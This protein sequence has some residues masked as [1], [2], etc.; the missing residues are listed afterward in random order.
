MIDDDA[1]DLIV[2][3]P[4]FATDQKDRAGLA[5]QKGKL[6][7]RMLQ[8][9]TDFPEPERASAGRRYADR[10]ARFWPAAEREKLVASVMSVLSHTELGP[11]FSERSQ[12]EV[13]IMGTL[14][15]EGRDYAISGR[16]DRLVVTEDRVIILDYKTNRVPPKNLDA[17]PLSH[18]AQ[19][20]IYREILRP[21]YPAKNFDCVL[22]YTESA[23][24]V[25]LP[26]ELLSRSLAELKTK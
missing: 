24:V 12:S 9:L 8:M 13:S 7:H 5:L 19:L 10:A 17:I 21:L 15:L 4:L 26:A 23:Q 20:A 11:V 6:V 3:S 1:D 2:T 25:T 14:T 16:I 22:V 18:R